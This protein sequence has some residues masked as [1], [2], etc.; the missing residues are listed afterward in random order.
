MV[1]LVGNSPDLRIRDQE[2]PQFKK[3]EVGAA[4]T[5]ERA[6]WGEGWVQRVTKTKSES[7]GRDRGG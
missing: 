3:L 2:M 5:E 1:S 4:G 7:T 6:K